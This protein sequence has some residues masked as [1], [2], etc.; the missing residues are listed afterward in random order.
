ML[1]LPAKSTISPT[2]MSFNNLFAASTFSLCESP[3]GIIL[4]YLINTSQ[5]NVLLVFR[6]PC[7]VKSPIGRLGGKEGRGIAS[8]KTFES[9]KTWK[10][11]NVH[12]LFKITPKVHR[13]PRKNIG[14]LSSIKHLVKFDS[15]TFLFDISIKPARPHILISTFFWEASWKK[16]LNSRI[17]KKFVPNFSS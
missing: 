15:R 14:F 16:C 4:E 3:H 17:S 9:C 13:E 8:V 7:F 2:Y 11:G 10:F 6:Q 1:L 12:A 5:V